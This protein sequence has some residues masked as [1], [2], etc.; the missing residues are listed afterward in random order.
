MINKRIASYTDEQ[1]DGALDLMKHLTPAQMAQALRGDLL[2][3]W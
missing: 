1:W 3:G 2:P